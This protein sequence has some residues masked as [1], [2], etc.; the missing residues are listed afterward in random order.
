MIDISGLSDGVYIVHVS[1]AGG[2]TTA[3]LVVSR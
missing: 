3:K 1:A 2:T